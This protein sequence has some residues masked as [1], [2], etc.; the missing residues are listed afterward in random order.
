MSIPSARATERR[1]DPGFPRVRPDQMTPDA[2]KDAS[3]ATQSK[4]DETVNKDSATEKGISDLQAIQIFQGTFENG[5][6]HG[7]LKQ[8]LP[9]IVVDPTDLSS[10]G[11]GPGEQDW[12]PDGTAT[13]EEEEEVLQDMNTSHSLF[14]DQPQ[15]SEEGT[16]NMGGAQ[17]RQSIPQANGQLSSS[18]LTPPPVCHSPE[19]MPPG[20]RS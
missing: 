6:P 17:R 13:T 12:P 3:L 15:A 14:S 5:R 20:A 19:E 7:D 18:R 11:N 1:I 9:S 4:M 8:R 16:R 2:A 10:P